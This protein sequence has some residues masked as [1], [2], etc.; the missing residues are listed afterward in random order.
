MSYDLMFQKAVD[1]QNAG[2]LNEAEGIYQQLLQVMPENSDVWNLLGMIAQ[3]KGDDIRAVDC[4]LTAIKYAPTPFFAHFFNLGI[5]YKTLNRAAEALEAL[6]RAARLAPKIKETWNFLGVLQ[7]ET[8]HAEEAVKSFCKALEIDEN[9]EE[10][11]VNLCLYTNDKTKLFEIADAAENNFAANFRAAECADDVE[12]K[13]YY[14]KRAVAAAPERTDGLLLAAEYYHTVKDFNTSLTFYHKVLNLDE[15]NV[16][17]L[18]GA[19]DIYLA[20]KEYD[21]AERYYLKSFEQNLEIAGAHL[22]Y[23]ILLY[24]TGRTAEAL[25]EYRK[26]AALAPEKP[27]I[28]YNLALILK[29]TGDLAEALGLMFNAHIKVPENQTI[30]INISETLS[31]L[32]KE[33]PELALKI[34]ENWHKQEPDNIFSARLFAG[35]AGTVAEATDAAYS[36]QLFDAFAAQYDSTIAKLNPKIISKFKEIYGHLQGH[37]LDLGCGTGLAAAALKNDKNSFDGVDISANMLAVAREKKLYDTLFQEDITSF[38]RNDLPAR[39]YDLVLAFDV[40]CYLGNLQEVLSLLK[41]NKICFS[42]ESAD[43]NRHENYYLTPNGRYK[44][45][46]SYVQTLLK[47]CGFMKIDAYPLV[48]RTENGENVN[49][50]LFI[51]E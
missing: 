21:K 42:V 9:Y 18:L 8:G 43:E 28:S 22:N 6:Q 33:N 16:S 17:A 13:L 51:A 32:F 19:A 47:A 29:E 31:L 26:A 35:M 7:A 39:S 12:R 37:I 30:T 38:L 23:G 11:R 24:Q 20:R 34:A 14:I 25:E 41:G 45:K 49:G 36:K 48:L 27:E 10:A 4:F 5:S 44:H 15:K 50:I 46:E 3:S 2:A 1:L 40:F